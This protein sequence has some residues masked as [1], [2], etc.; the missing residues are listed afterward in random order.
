MSAL[1]LHCNLIYFVQKP[2]T[3]LLLLFLL[4]SLQ[5]PPQTIPPLTHT[6]LGHPLCPCSQCLTLTRI[7]YPLSPLVGLSF[8]WLCIQVWNIRLGVSSFHKYQRLVWIPF[9][10]WGR[11]GL[12]SSA[13]IVVH[14]SPNTAGS[15]LPKEP[16]K[17]FGN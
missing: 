9:F 10:L 6:D 12:M 2:C 8:I 11:G 15:W 3:A 1:H 7:S 5:T 13:F 14:R 16:W 4:T 17:S